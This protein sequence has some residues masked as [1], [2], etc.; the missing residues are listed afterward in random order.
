[1][2][3]PLTAFMNAHGIDDQSNVS[4]GAGKTISVKTS[5]ASTQPVDVKVLEL[6]GSGQQVAMEFARELKMYFFHVASVVVHDP[7]QFGGAL[8]GTALERLLQPTIAVV[9]KLRTSYGKRLARLLG[10]M[11]AAAGGRAADEQL[12][13]VSVSWGRLVEPALP[14]ILLA[15]QAAITARDA[16]LI[17]GQTAIRFVA[18]Y[19]GVE[20]VAELDERL[21]TNAEGT[22]TPL[23]QAGD[24]LNALANI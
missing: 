11:L 24:P 1:M 19:F 18:D 13:P 22:A 14:D 15:V 23:D 12:E 10:K 17:D 4:R 16:G 6:S 8:S 20:N 5:P 3:E 2:I 9:G 21:G 7:D